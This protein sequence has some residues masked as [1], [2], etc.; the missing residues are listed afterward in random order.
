MLDRWDVIV[1]LIREHGLQTGV[2]IG[3]N[4]GRNM[5][6]VLQQCPDFQ[7]IAVDDWRVGYE[8]MEA[9]QRKA[10]RAD[11]MQVKARWPGNITLIEAGS[12][13]AVG[14][15]NG[16]VDFVFVDGDHEYEGCLADIDLWL[17]K[18]RPGGVMAGHDFGD[19][20][21]G[22]EKAVRERFEDFEVHEASVWSTT[23]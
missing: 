1:G 13:E 18:I 14:L 19:R 4:R 10:Q 15:V 12:E 20:F 17:P 16:P 6:R 23:L 22:V 8:G 11:F 9:K 2:E 7:W 21:P 3:V 5:E